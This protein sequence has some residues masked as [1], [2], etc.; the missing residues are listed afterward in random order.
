M[1]NYTEFT[2]KTVEEAV[3]N[4]LR[5][6]GLSREEAEIRVLEEGKKKLFGF[7]KARVEIAPKNDSDAF[8]DGSEEDEYYP[9]SGS[10]GSGKNAAESEYEG[11]KNYDVHRDAQGRTDGERAVEFLEGLFDILRITACTELMREEE[12][13]EINVTAA[14]TTAIIGKR[15]AMLDAI[16]TIAGAVANTG[17]EE[18]KRVVVDCENYRENREATLQRLAAKL[19]QKAVRFEKKIRLEPMNPYER[20]IIHSALADNPDVTT[21]SEG[22]EPHRYV[23]IVPNNVRYPDRPAPPAR[24]ERSD[25]PRRGGY[26][27][28]RGYSRGY[29]KNYGRDNRGYGRKEGR[30]D[31]GENGQT[32]EERGYNKPYGREERNYGRREN[33]NRDNYNRD[34][35]GENG[36]NNDRRRDGT[37]TD[38]RGYDRPYDK[39]RTS[40]KKPA[41]DFFGTYLGNSRDNK[42]TEQPSDDDQN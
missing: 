16:Q 20:R 29:N 38:R 4:G 5:E 11:E 13:I 30:Y 8:E 27:R 21:Q 9:L 25:R 39:T 40:Y 42:E 3:E 15:G 22:K 10:K 17:R 18:Y 32:G 7:V 2:G 6:L 34:R 14:N 12:K 28:D 35:N 23:V 1:K 37:G 19:A 36:R 33:Y 31:N 26:D 24:F 41:T